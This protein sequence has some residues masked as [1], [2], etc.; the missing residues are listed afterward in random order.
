MTG[1]GANVSETTIG[2]GRLYNSGSTFSAD[3]SFFFGLDTLVDR[4]VSVSDFLAAHE[5]N[6]LIV[7][8]PTASPVDYALTAFPNVSLPRATITAYG[9]TGRFR[10]ILTVSE[11]K[12]ALLD[13]VKYSLFAT[14]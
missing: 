4:S 12:S 1:V 2:T 11:N 3:G 7:Y 6:Y 13:A 10:Q 14:E 9:I 8:N 5:E